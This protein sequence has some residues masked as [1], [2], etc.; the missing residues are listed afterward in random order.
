MLQFVTYCVCLTTNFVPSLTKYRDFLF[1]SLA[2][3]VGT[4]VVAVFWAVWH[5]AGRENILPVE[6]GC[7]DWLNHVSHTIMLPINFVQLYL[8]NHNYLSDKFSILSLLAYL[9]TYNTYLLYIR[10]RSGRFVYKFM[11]KMSVAIIGVFIVCMFALTVIIYKA[12][13]YLH[14]HVHRKDN[15]LDRAE[16]IV[17]RAEYRPSGVVTTN[18]LSKANGTVHS[19]GLTLSII[20]DN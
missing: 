15:Q 14:G 12:G 17:V 7:P 3:P 16:Q 4:F 19:N 2:L 20:G 13:R 5:I 11:D 1:T 8:V 6:A 9:M 18:S 10:I